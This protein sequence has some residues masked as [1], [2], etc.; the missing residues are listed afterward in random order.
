MK[1]RRTIH[2][3]GGALLIARTLWEFALPYRARSR[4]M[5]AAPIAAARPAGQDVV[6]DMAATRDRARIGG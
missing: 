5:R 4:S 1:C 2:S 3:I 6:R